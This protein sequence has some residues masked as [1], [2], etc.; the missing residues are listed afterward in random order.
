MNLSRDVIF[1]DIEDKTVIW[2]ENSNQYVVLEKKAAEIVEQLH[3]NI[4]IEAIAN[5]L[6]KE[7]DLSLSEALDFVQNLEKNIILPNQNNATDVVSKIDRVIV[8]SYFELSK[9]YKIGTLIFKIDYLSEFEL[10]LVHPK[11]AHLEI[12]SEEK[13]DHHYQVFTANKHTFLYVDNTLI[14]RWLYEDIHYFQGKLSMQI[15]QHVH[16]KPEKDWLGVFHASAVSDGRNGMLFLGDSGNGKSTSLA[17][18]QAHNFHCIADDFV[19]VSAMTQ[20][21]YAFPAAISIKKNSLDVLLPFYPE[22]N[23][24]AEYNFTRLK[25][26]V[27]FLPPHNE[28]SITEVPCKGFVFIKYDKEVDFELTDIPSIK[29]FEKLVPDSW[30]SPI[31]DNVN[32]FLQWFATIPCYK[33]TYSNNDK[34]ISEVSKLF[35]NVL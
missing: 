13:I 8:P 17:L 26:V 10:S 22:L 7:F 25:K 11:F 3:Q 5:S 4:P 34:M 35:A 21:I 23:T 27:R 32:A 31:S 16:Q 1:K 18:L 6:A 2:F 28:N 19:P 24:S 20:D 15:V 33:V 12:F 30:L 29:A 14:D 9:L